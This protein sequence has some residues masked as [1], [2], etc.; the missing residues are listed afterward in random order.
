MSELKLTLLGSPQAML[1]EKSMVVE[2]RKALALLFYLAVTQQRHSRDRLATL[3]WPEQDQARARASLR[4]VVWLLRN[5]GLEPWLVIDQDALELQ[6]GY[7]C[8]VH[9]FRAE[10]A[11]G[12]LAAALALYQDDLLTGFSLRDCPEF[13]QW[14]FLQADELRRKL[15]NA[16]EESVLRCLEQGDYARGLD[17]ARRWLALDPLHEPVHRHLMLLY[18]YA[19]QQAAAL[20]QYEECVRLLDEELGVAP[21]AATTSLYQAI[22][23]RQIAPSPAAPANQSPATPPLSPQTDPVARPSATS[24]V[25]NNLPTQLTPFLGRETELDE[26]E[27]ILADADCRLVTVLG[28]GGIGK[29]RLAVQV[30]RRF[31]DTAAFPHADPQ[32]FPDG[33]LFVGLS[34]V[35]SPSG[36]IVA[37]AEA[38]GFIFYHD[39]DPRQQLIEYLRDKKLLLLLDNFE[40]LLAGAD[41][42]G[43]LLTHVP[44][45]TLLVTSREALNLH[46]EW[47]WPVNGLPS[48]EEDTEE[49]QIWDYSAV[50][51]FVQS[52]APRPARFFTL[53]QLQRSRPHLPV[54]R[55][56]AA[57]HR[58]G[59]RMAASAAL[60][61]DR[62]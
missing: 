52:R 13:D 58:V 17:Y 36:I 24:I 6:A 31:V 12:N 14:Q 43:H 33:V 60:R 1:G 4:Q 40:H 11:A 10:L 49:A 59:R 25:F 45:I 34:A 41:F 29:T 38:S 7:W 27:K 55:W 61:P 23:A 57:G 50:R 16:L 42:V 56:H 54:G 9:E 26:L 21:E 51:M 2:S 15:A 53:G 35:D 19:G 48:P 20:R 39:L 3:F 44:T 18:A 37:I 47:Q 32:I 30:A 28:P 8:D 5:A 22:K 62:A 46:G